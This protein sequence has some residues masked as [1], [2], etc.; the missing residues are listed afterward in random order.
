MRARTHLAAIGET[1]AARILRD[2]RG[3]DY[4]AERIALGE[5][6]ARNITDEAEQAVAMHLAAAAIERTFSAEV[7]HAS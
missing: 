6:L 2:A 5:L 4:E 1:I 3:D 7:H